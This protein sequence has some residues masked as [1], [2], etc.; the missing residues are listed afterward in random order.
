MLNFKNY[1]ENNIEE[2]VHGSYSYRVKIGKQKEYEIMQ[3]A[4]S[5]L[6]WNFE[7]A[8][9]SEDRNE[10]IDFWVTKVK[11]QKISRIP[12]QVKS[13][14]GSKYSDLIWETVKPF[15]EQLK[16]EYSKK[17]SIKFTGKDI[18]C[19]AKY[20]LFL[21]NLGNEI[22]FFYTDQI[23]ENAKFLTNRFF[24]NL[25]SIG[26]NSPFQNSIGKVS[27]LLDPDEES[28]YRLRGD[29]YKI[30]CHLN[31]KS[32]KCFCKIKA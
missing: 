6:N 4:A 25:I 21:N 14:E 17:H 3:V 20:V 5:E 27:L 32:L 24:E 22:S 9:E 1:I 31:T 23:Q 18:K 11:G 19:K 12:I 13:R 7:E 10:G 16:D 26:D 29:I 28:N 30:I 15:Y 2:A 8:S